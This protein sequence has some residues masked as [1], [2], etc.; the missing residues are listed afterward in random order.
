MKVR[1]PFALLLL[2]SLAACGRN[3]EPRRAVA[4]VRQASPVFKLP[5]DRVSIYPLGTAL[6]DQ[7]ADSEHLDVFA[8]HP[9]VISMFY[10]SCPM[11]CPTLVRDI[12]KLEQ[13]LDPA[14]R[15]DLRVLLVSFDPARD[16][17]TALHAMAEAHAV[18]QARWHLARTNADEARALAGVLGIQYRRVGTGEFAHS[19]VISILDRKGAVVAREE[20][21]PDQGELVEAIEAV[22]AVP[23]G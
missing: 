13:G 23:A 21:R 18:D 19:V 8:G 20:G 22:E 14:T 17:P 10:G 12:K 9:V 4:S 15:A 16:T 1:L 5:T 7:N 11:A 6:T 2:L 3:G